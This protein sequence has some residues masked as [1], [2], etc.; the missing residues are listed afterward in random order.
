MIPALERFVVGV[1]VQAIHNAL[2]PSSIDGFK[3]MPKNAIAKPHA[4]SFCVS[5]TR[6][7]R[8]ASVRPS[9]HRDIVNHSPDSPAQERGEGEADHSCVQ[10]CLRMSIL[11]LA[12]ATAA[13]G[14]DHAKPT[15][16]AENDTPSMTTGLRSA[17]RILACHKPCPASKGSI[18]KPS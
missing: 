8:F 14:F 7:D 5:T 4:R 9:M 6:K 17:R 18:L 15:S 3:Q 11:D 10:R 16:S 1:P 2:K 12:S 13:S